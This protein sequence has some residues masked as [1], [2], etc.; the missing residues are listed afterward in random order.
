MPG[1]VL[2]LAEQNFPILIIQRAPALLLP[3]RVHRAI[4]RDRLL[5]PLPVI[6]LLPTVL[7]HLALRVLTVTHPNLPGA[8]AVI[9]LVLISLGLPIPALAVA[10]ALVLA[11]GVVLILRTGLEERVQIAAA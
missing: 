11:A 4:L 7:H 5:T 1:L 2:V 10:R 3:R 9:G 6:R 8:I